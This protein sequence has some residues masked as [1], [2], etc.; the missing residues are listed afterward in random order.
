[1]CEGGK[2]GSANDLVVRL[3]TKRM[4]FVSCSK[5]VAELLTEVSVTRLELG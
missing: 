1:M 3:T 4:V 5:Q 2:G